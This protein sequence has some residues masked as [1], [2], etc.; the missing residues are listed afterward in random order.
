M[1]FWL[2]H[3]IGNTTRFLFTKRQFAKVKSNPK[4]QISALHIG[5]AYP[6]HQAVGAENKKPVANM[7]TYGRIAVFSE[8]QPCAGFKIFLFITYRKIHLVGTRSLHR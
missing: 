5:N 3:A 2:V 8:V 6:F 4:V 7:E 1:L